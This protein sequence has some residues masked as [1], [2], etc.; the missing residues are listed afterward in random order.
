MAWTVDDLVLL[1]EANVKIDTDIFAEAFEYEN[2]NYLSVALPCGQCGAA[3]LK[4]HALSCSHAT[5]L[6]RA[7]WYEELKRRA[8]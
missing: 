1:R 2:R 4:Q 5:V 8:E 6:V 7:D 3:P